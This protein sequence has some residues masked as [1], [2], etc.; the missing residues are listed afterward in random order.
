METKLTHFNTIVIGSGPAGTGLLY[1]AQK[2]GH[3][4]AL[5]DSG[6]AFIDSTDRF[7]KGS[8]GNHIVNS[9][10]SA[11]V[12]LECLDNL[13]DVHTFSPAL[14]S[15]VQK[16]RECGSKAIPLS[17]VGRLLELL[18]EYWKIKLESSASSAL[19]LDHHAQFIRQNPDESFTVFIRDH[20]TGETSG[21]T[22]SHL[23]MAMG[24]RQ[25]LNDVLN[26]KVNDSVPLAA[27]RNKIMLTGELLCPGGPQR[28]LQLMQHNSSHRVVIIGGSHSAFSSATTMLKTL[29]AQH[30]IEKGDITMLH[31]HKLKLFYG[32][33]REA[34]ADGYTD[35]T[36]NDICPVTLR[37]NRLG[38]IRFESKELLRK[39]MG[40][41]NEKEDRV[42]LDLLEKYTHSELSEL[43]DKAGL[44]VPAFGYKP[45][46]LPVFDE[47]EHPIPLLAQYGVKL[48]DGNCRVLHFSGEPVKGLFAAGLASGFVPHGKMGGEA[49]FRGQTNSLWGYQNCVG[50]LI[51]EQVLVTEEHYRRNAA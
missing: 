47:Q 18:G 4:E 17:W 33:A 8:I 2:S 38:G 51:L 36:L 13:P 44:I 1:A 32:S 24:G 43:F 40:I 14:Q 19:F 7:G 48:V 26:V 29:E 25:S 10:T 6:V 41:S 31:R 21:L 12:F 42:K 16:I 49:S 15:L 37:V 5:L 34:E 50:E 3:L 39:L 27:Y 28:A 20:R 46:V 35:F 22:A 45:R 9:D 23:V 30:K 11:S